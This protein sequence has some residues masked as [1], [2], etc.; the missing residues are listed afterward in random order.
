[1]ASSVCSTSPTPSSL[2]PTTIEQF[3]ENTL[4]TNADAIVAQFDGGH[5]EISGFLE[6]LR[7]AD[8]TREDGRVECLPLFVARALPAGVIDA[9]TWRQLTNMLLASVE[10]ALE[11]P[12]LDGILVAPHGATVSAE[13]PDAD[14]HW[15]ARLRQLVGND[16]WVGGTLDLHA[17][18]SP[19]MVDACNFLTAYRTNPHLDQRHRGIEAARLM[20]SAV[21]GKTRPVLRA[22]FPPLAIAIDRQ[23]TAA[24]W[25]A[26]VYQQAAQLRGERINE[27]EQGQQAPGGGATPSSP[28]L[29]STSLLLGFPYADVEEMGA[30]TMAVADGDA[31]QAEAA[32]QQLVSALLERRDQYRSQLIAVEQALDQC[33][34]M[35]APVCLLDM[36]DNVGG[37]S[38]ADGTALLAALVHRSFSSFV[39]ICDPESVEQAKRA[40]VGAELELTLGGKTDAIHGEP[41]VAMCRVCSLHDGRFTESQP[42]H[43]GMSQFDQG[44]TAVLESG[45]VTIMLTTRRMTPF[46]LQQL[47]SCDVA[48][49]GFQAIVAKGVHAPLAAYR[50]VCPSLIRVNTPGSTTAD[51]CALNYQHRR[52]PLFPFESIE[53]IAAE[54][55][56]ADPE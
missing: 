44:A 25:L 45:P 14:G 43:G 52:R 1:M 50:E 9:E 3:R 39:C 15:L 46:S 53:P 36:G 5:H 19:K 56:G 18:L 16:M 47:I 33:E 48:P 4:L 23:D 29:L 22:A 38:T 30:A 55:D 37:G 21:A 8:L 51:M 11:S 20:V 13:H 41:V 12:G 34:S 32:A 10:A 40:G 49:Q 26:E 54:T 31:G 7:Q 28:A 17:N 27:D 35:P 24:P 6:G 2:A 42:R